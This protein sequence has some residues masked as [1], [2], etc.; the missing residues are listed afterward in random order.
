MELQYDHSINLLLKEFQIKLLTEEYVERVLP[1]FIRAF[2]DSE[3]MTRY[4]NMEY[5]AF[6][7]F[8]KAVVNKAVKDQLS[9]VI[10]H[11]NRVVA[12]AL[13][14]DLVDPLL[15]AEPFTPKFEPIFTLLE[16][17][18]RDF[19]QDKIVLPNQIAHLF[20][21][22]VDE[23]FRGRKL[24]RL[25]NF[26]AMEAALAKNFKFMCSELTNI[27]NEVGTLNHMHTNKLLLGSIVYAEFVFNDQKPFAELGGEAHGYLWELVQGATLE[28]KQHNHLVTLTLDELKKQ[29]R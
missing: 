10:L 14:E 23:D 26:G 3:P 20:I 25:V 13:V 9:T 2:C 12:C 16:Q 27:Y 11:G 21:T 22:A 7:V 29:Q 24:S 15:I 17:L 8:A 28:F 1:M 5:D 18:S 6:S 19:F 4:I